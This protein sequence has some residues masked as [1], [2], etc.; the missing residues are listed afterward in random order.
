[1]AKQVRWSCPNGC[2]GVLG[3]RQPRRSASVRYCLT[4][5]AKSPTLVERTAPALERQRE[6]RAHKCIVKLAER[7]RRVAT[8]IW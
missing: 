3:P 7:K 1:M 2:P 4:C 6:A 5:S 8:R